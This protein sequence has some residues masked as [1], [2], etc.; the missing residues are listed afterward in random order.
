MWSGN[1]TVVQL[2]KFTETARPGTDY[3]TGSST[4]PVHTSTVDENRLLM[5]QL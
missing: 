1:I 3:A 2:E 5:D 4:W